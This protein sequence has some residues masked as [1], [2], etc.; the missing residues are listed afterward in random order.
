MLKHMVSMVHVIIKT[1][2]KNWVYLQN[3][4]SSPAIHFMIQNLVPNESY[5]VVLLLKG[6]ICKVYKLHI[7]EFNENISNGRK[8]VEKIKFALITLPIYQLFTF[9]VYETWY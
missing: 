9:T 1:I 4:H 5:V 2:L 6:P 8:L 3:T 7:N